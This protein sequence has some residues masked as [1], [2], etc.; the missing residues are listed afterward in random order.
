M[1]A[2]ARLRA[3][4]A[5]QLAPPLAVSEAPRQYVFDE[6]SAAY[7]EIDVRR[8]EAFAVVIGVGSLPSEQFVVEVW[9]RFVAEVWL[10]DPTDE[11]IYVACAGAPVRVVGRGALLR[12]AALPGAAIDVEAL[13][14][15]P[16]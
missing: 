12:S 6:E 4:L 8:G 1:I 15:P 9:H 13:F 16:S 5:R 2:I 3:Q 10:V 7:A 11:A 14:A